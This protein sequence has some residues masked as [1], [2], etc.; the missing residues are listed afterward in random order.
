MRNEFFSWAIFITLF[1]KAVADCTNDKF[2]T[3]CS[4]NGTCSLCTDNLEEASRFRILQPNG[5]C[6]AYGPMDSDHLWQSV[7]TVNMSSTISN[8]QFDEEND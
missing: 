8:F 5:T 4:S 1:F 6:F 7:G 2:C 3:D